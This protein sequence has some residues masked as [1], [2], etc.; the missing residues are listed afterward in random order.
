MC[1]H[2]TRKYKGGRGPF[3]VVKKIHSLSFTHTI[4]FKGDPLTPAQKEKVKTSVY[5]PGIRKWVPR[6]PP[7]TD[8][9]L[10][11]W[12]YQ[13]RWLVCPVTGTK[14]S[15]AN[16]ILGLGMFCLIGIVCPEI[17]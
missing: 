2:H 15:D 9:E 17:N 1:A 6:D 11:C 8:E 13:S 5:N 7:L 10:E 3:S 12:D 14:W 4:Q 16:S